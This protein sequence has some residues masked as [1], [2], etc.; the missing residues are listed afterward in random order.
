MSIDLLD[1]VLGEIREAGVALELS[2]AGWRKPVGELYPSGGII[3]QARGKAIPV[4]IAS[5]AHSRF[6]KG[7]KLRTPG[8]KDVAV[9]DQPGLRYERHHRRLVALQRRRH[10]QPTQDSIDSRAYFSCNSSPESIRHGLSQPGC[11]AFL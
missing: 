2:T 5:D 4:T 11:F 8:R 7:G 10:P 9:R 6:Q 1:A 3:R